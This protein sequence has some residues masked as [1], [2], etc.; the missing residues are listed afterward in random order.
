[1]ALPSS[2]IELQYLESTGT[3][4]INTNIV[5][6]GTLTQVKGKV[7]KISTNGT[8]DCVFGAR[9][10]GANT[11]YLGANSSNKLYYGC[12]A[13]NGDNLTAFSIGTIYE[14]ILTKTNIQFGTWTNTHSNAFTGC[15]RVMWIFHGNNFDSRFKGRIY[16]LKPWNYIV[17]SYCCNLL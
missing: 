6:P 5:I 7:C 2:Y 3:Q 16:Y 13:N 11:L 14:F 1:M 15:D 8:W 17:I 9:N 12:G 10:S 4:Y